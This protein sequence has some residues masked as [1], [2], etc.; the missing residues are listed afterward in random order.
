MD[1]V[2]AVRQALAWR[3][4]PRRVSAG[5]ASD[6]LEKINEVG[7]YVTPAPG[8]TGEHVPGAYREVQAGEKWPAPVVRAEP[9]EF[10]V[11]HDGPRTALVRRSQINTVSVAAGG[12]CVILL[13]DGTRITGKEAVEEIMALLGVG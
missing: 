12:G 8:L 6:V 10:L 9:G 2:E 1:A 11:L 5:E 3:D 4:S 13:A 7:F